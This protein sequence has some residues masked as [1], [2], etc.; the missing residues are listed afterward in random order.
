MKNFRNIILLLSAAAIA[1]CEGMGGGAGNAPFTLSLD[2]DVIESD[3]KDAATLVI[4]DSKGNVMTTPENLRKTSFY[5]EETKEWQSGMGSDTP[6]VFTSIIDGTYTISAMYNGVE[7]E[8]K[9]TVT[10]QNRKTYEKFHKNVAIY[11][12]TSVACTYCPEMS[13][14][15]SNIND[16][17]R[18]HSVLLEFHSNDIGPDE[19]T[20]PYNDL[21]SALARMYGAGYPFCIYSI[22]EGS[23]KRT[24]N[25]IQRLVK[26]QLVANPARTG[27]KATSS[28]VDGR[29]TVNAEVTASAP[30]K[31]D[32]GMAVLRDNCIPSGPAYEDRYDDVVENI[33][34]NYHGIS[35]DAFNLE[36]DESRTFTRECELKTDDRKNYR[37]ALFTLVEVNG[38]AIID[39]I[40]EFK[41]GESVD[42]R[43]N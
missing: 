29:L 9:V 15:L 23:G 27:I 30:G 2:K 4:T 25:D 24:V 22:A 33:S 36:V 14:A 11:R 7:C 5:I 35:V 42:Y 10:S 12:L 32:L 8:N 34:G 37:V 31:Y 6:N 17:T 21:G 40:V 13:A 43:Y 38:K 41:A 16:Y 28:V 18:D 3:G 39:N 26:N 19:F 20:I 1:A